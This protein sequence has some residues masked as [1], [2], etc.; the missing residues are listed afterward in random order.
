MLVEVRILVRN[1]INFGLFYKYLIIT[2]MRQEKGFLAIIFFVIAHSTLSLKMSA[3]PGMAATIRLAGYVVL[4]NDD[5]L[6]GQI[7]WSLKYVENNPVEIKFIAENGNS[8]LFNAA[9]IKGFGNIIPGWAADDPQFI[10]QKFQDYVSVPSFKKS[11]PVF[12][13]RLL[14]GRLTVLQN[15]SSGIIT[16]SK[17][18]EKSRIDGIGFIWNPGEGLSVGPT[19]QIDYRIIEGK[20]RF[21]SYFVSKEN[22]PIIKIDKDN[23]E[24][25]FNIFFG[26]CQAI[27]QE[28]NKNPDLKKFQNFMILA[29]VYNRICLGE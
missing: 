26:D 24:E 23:Y 8:K 22:K 21:T 20:T 15:R 5:T 9:E 27:L 3:Q 10:D 16:T 14:A 7:R 17:T 25:N 12:M 13:H 19:Y 29:E 2:I 18:V 11:I 1:L 28:L 4:A 6:N